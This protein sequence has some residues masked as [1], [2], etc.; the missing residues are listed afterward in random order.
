MTAGRRSQ[1]PRP[2]PSG[3]HSA[4]A[5]VPETPRLAAQ[6]TDDTDVPEYNLSTSSVSTSVTRR[7]LRSDTARGKS[8][9]AGPQDATTPL[10]APTATT[11][12]KDATKVKQTKPRRKRNA[13]TGATAPEEKLEEKDEGTS[14]AP[15]PSESRKRRRVASDVGEG[16]TEPQDTGHTETLHDEAGKVNQSATYEHGLTHTVAQPQSEV[17]HEPQNAAAATTWPT[18]REAADVFWGTARA[19]PPAPAHRPLAWLTTSRGR[20]ARPSFEQALADEP[21]AEEPAR[22]GPRHE[23]V[24]VTDPVEGRPWQ[25]HTTT[26]ADWSQHERPYPSF[27][28]ASTLS[29]VAEEDQVRGQEVNDGPA[30]RRPSRPARPNTPEF[31]SGMYATDPADEEDIVMQTD[32]DAHTARISEPQAI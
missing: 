9:E 8:S 18:P 3:T 11:Q 26:A 30:P 23:A 10:P 16:R 5:E 6:A 29:R 22:D 2:A 17:N 4:G 12:P 21:V 15:P 20:R 25:L 31:M 13:N 7:Q 28:R 1:S 32:S 14:T 19:A 27:V 24:A